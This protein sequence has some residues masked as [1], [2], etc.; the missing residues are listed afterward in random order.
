MLIKSPENDLNVF[1][2]LTIEDREGVMGMFVTRYRLKSQ[3]EGSAQRSTN[4]AS[5]YMGI[6]TQ[7]I[8]DMHDPIG[9]EDPG[10]EPGTPGGGG[11]NTTYPTDCPGT[12][13]TTTVVNEI[14][15]G[16]GHTWQQLMMGICTGCTSGYPIYPSM[17]T[18]DVYECVTGTPSD[19]GTGGGADT[20]VGGGIGS[21]WPDI[22]DGNSVTIPINPDGTSAV[23][24]I[25][26]NFLGLTPEQKDMLADQPDLAN[27]LFQFLQQDGSIEAKEFAIAAI[28]AWTEGGEVDFA[29]R[30][31]LSNDFTEN[32]CLYSIYEEMGKATTIKGYLQN[33]DPSFT[34][35]VANLQLAVGVHSTYPNATAVTEEPNNYMIKILF[36]PNELSRPK[37]DVA[38][39]MIH[40]L[41]H[42]EMYRKL[43]EVAQQPN[44]PW[45]REFIHTLRNNYEG[46]ADYYTRY[47]LELPLGQA[48]TDP[49][50]EQMAE[51]FIDVII[52]ALKDIDNSLTD[53]QYK[54]IAWAGLKG[55]GNTLSATTGL[56]SNPTIAWS[57]V[58]LSERLLLNNIYENF[59]ATNLNCQ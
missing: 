15:C 9:P 17:E 36:N 40:E 41:I 39:T 2:N 34:N 23:P 43:L 48:P 58:P 14:R 42:A 22:G 54:A 25:L 44:I 7:R 1:Y 56:P 4:N 47:W 38:R 45:T 30:V 5:Q 27:E 33:F 10:N 29:N 52:Q 3:K 20:G 49:Q 28:E 13:V 53:L 21:T 46:L 37:L 55:S 26:A 19:P 11:G 59:K 16:C 32:E 57:N 12:I 31:I 35:P 8:D 24:D 18:I 50:H 6:T 51:H